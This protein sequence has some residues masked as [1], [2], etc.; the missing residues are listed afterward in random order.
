MSVELVPV[1]EHDPA[2]DRLA[3]TAGEFFRIE[4]ER[5]SPASLRQALRERGV[6]VLKAETGEI[7]GGLAGYVVNPANHR[8]ATVAV[9]G[10]EPE[11]QTEIL[12]ALIELLRAAARIRSFVAVVRADSPLIGTYRGLGFTSV[13]ALRS[14]RYHRY[15]RHDELV[16]HHEPAVKEVPADAADQ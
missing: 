12:Q 8:Q 9:A 6:S 14:S 13:G 16:L 15:R 7:P 10:F 1:N 11:G 3:M 5:L 2:I 4:L